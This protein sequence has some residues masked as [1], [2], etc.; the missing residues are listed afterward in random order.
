M[1]L[2]CAVDVVGIA[3]EFADDDGDVFLEDLAGLELHRQFAMGGVVL[4]DEDH[5]ARVLVEPVDDA[6]RSWPFPVL[7]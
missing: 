2:E 4:G 3:A 5:A 1:H 6:R 7:S